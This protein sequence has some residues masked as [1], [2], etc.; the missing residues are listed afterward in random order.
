MTEMQ[1][2]AIEIAAAYY[3]AWTTGDMN[4]AAQQLAVDVICYA[5][6]GT[7]EGRDAVKSFMA[8]YAASL[9]D[10][11]LLAVYGTDHEAVIMYDT[12]NRSVPTA[13]AAELYRIRDDHIAEIHIIFDRLPFALARGDVVAV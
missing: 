7:I 8:P 5:P 3:R 13:P 6:S 12:A 9:T 2:K 4:G 1:A 10:S 11:T